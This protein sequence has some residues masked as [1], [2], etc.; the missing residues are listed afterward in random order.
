M[1]AAVR[2]RTADN[3]EAT[4]A[5]RSAIGER[6][7]PPRPAFA[8][9]AAPVGK[10]A[11]PPSSG[12]GD[13][14]HPQ[15]AAAGSQRERKVQLTSPAAATVPVPAMDGRGNVYARS[16]SPSAAGLATLVVVS[17]PVEAGDVVVIDTDVPGSARLARDEADPKVFGIVTGT[18][19]VVLG[20][21]IPGEYAPSAVATTDRTVPAWD[22]PAEMDRTRSGEEAAVAVSGVVLC[23]VDADYGSIR[24]GD[25]LTTSR[26]GGHARRAADDPPAGTLLGKALEPLDYGT[27]R[28]RILVTLR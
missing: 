11:R 2:G 20:S 1:E 26:T 9:A 13:S 12:D 6:H 27:G 5:L 23:K 3:M 17:E 24:P 18:S 15:R 28:M 8:G 14:P 25:L 4:G 10:L 22:E 19:G 7:E 21:A 16:F